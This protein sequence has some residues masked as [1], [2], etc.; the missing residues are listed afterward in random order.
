[1]NER[2]A[3]TPGTGK[4]ELDLLAI[5]SYLWRRRLAIAAGAT[6]AAM[7]GIAYGYL[8]TPMY[9]AH[10]IISPKE[11]GGGGGSSALLSQLGGF[12]GVVAGQ[13][14]VG[15][16]D[17][18]RLELMTRSRDMAEYIV[19]RHD[20][21]PRL[22]PKAW[23]PK[24]KAWKKGRAPTARQGADF[25]KSGVISISTDPKK[26][27][28]TLGVEIHDSTLAARLVEYYIDAL[29]NT[30]KLNVRNDADS[31]RNYL[32]SQL[33]NTADPLLREKI[34]QLIGIEIEKAMLVSSKSFDVMERAV[35]P[36]IPSKPRKKQLAII[37]FCLGLLA[38]SLALIVTKAIRENQ[39]LQARK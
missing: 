10:C 6:L 34:Q 5:I 30:I 1:M 12:G 7:A 18:N 27:A 28:L 21:L 39:L 22:F 3:G 36:S 35:V 26:G 19:E 15:N 17:L 13:L 16:A 9:Q 32:E 11:Q 25:L 20:L 31:N 8:T 29:S 23:D 24:A 33:M 2:Q 4:D 14:G 38:T 37:S